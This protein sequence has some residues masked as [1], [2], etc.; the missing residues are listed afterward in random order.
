MAAKNTKTKKRR[1]NITAAAREKGAVSKSQRGVFNRYIK[2]LQGRAVERNRLKIEEI[3][4][5]LESGTRIKKAPVFRDGH[6]VGTIE[7]ALPLLPS[8]RAMWMARK[9]KLEANLTRSAPD[10]LHKEF[11]AM[12][13]DYAAR[14]NLTREILISVGVPESDLDAVGLL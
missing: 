10:E 12:L 3:A 9:Q 8:E 1:G 2:S 14:N 6:R 7:K 5:M 4:R 13:P 11:L